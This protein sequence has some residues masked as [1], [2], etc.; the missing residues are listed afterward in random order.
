[1]K[2]P[3]KI[4]EFRLESCFELKVIHFFQIINNNE[5]LSCVEEHSAECLTPSISTALGL[6][7]NL[8]F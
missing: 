3:N 4:T 2:I 8:F 1:M 5:S 7:I 6:F